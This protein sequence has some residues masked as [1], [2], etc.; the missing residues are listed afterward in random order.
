[1]VLPDHQ[2]DNQQHGGAGR[3]EAVT[4]DG[5]TRKPR[6]SAAGAGK[7]VPPVDP[8]LYALYARFLVTRMCATC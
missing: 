5:H 3:G 6:P 8:V 1:A 4:S 7:P 2:P